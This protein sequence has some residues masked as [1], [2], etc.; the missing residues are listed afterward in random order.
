MTPQSQLRAGIC[1]ALL[2][3]ALATASPTAACS[4]AAPDRSD[5]S[6][7][8]WV[9][10]VDEIVLARVVS[11]RGRTRSESE[12]D[13]GSDIAPTGFHEFRFEVVEQLKGNTPRQF[14]L[15]GTL[16]TASDP[17]NAVVTLKHTRFGRFWLYFAPEE[18]GSNAACQWS[19]PFAFDN[20]Y[21]IF[22]NKSGSL[23]RWFGRAV[24]A[25]P[26]RHDPWLVAVRRL[27]ANP[28]LK[29]GR[30]ATIPQ[31]LASSVFAVEMVAD[32]CPTSP[33]PPPGT[34]VSA[35]E[36]TGHRI[37]RQLWGAPVEHTDRLDGIVWFD[38]GKCRAGERRLAVYF[39]DETYNG[40]V[41]RLAVVDG[42]VDFGG[43]A[44]GTERG[45]VG[46]SSRYGIWYSQLELPSKLIW[47]TDELAAALEAVA[48]GRSGSGGVE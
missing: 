10:S 20:E 37:V 9:A 4:F 47:T 38:D 3:G 6:I 22:R 30:A 26:A 19:P 14:T 40:E 16:D 29:F 31:V 33:P 15:N 1:V 13:Y 23:S 42:K 24:Q 11:M 41:L 5:V 32:R 2:C 35:A 46:S 7:S 28:K 44:S 36:S 43:L 34:N 12:A 17:S 45:L 25:I 27:I 8:K 18:G 48:A 39:Q 21:L